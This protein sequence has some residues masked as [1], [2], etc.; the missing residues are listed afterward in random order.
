V[1]SG[2]HYEYLIEFDRW[3]GG[4][5]KL[6]MEPWRNVC[7]RPSVLGRPSYLRTGETD[8]KCD[9]M[10][11]L[12]LSVAYDLTFLILSEARLRRPEL[13]WTIVRDPVKTAGGRS[14]PLNLPTVE[15]EGSVLV[16]GIIGL[17]RGLLSAD[18]V[19]ISEVAAGSDA[20]TVHRILRE[21]VGS[22]R[23]LA[24]SGRR[25]ERSQGVREAPVNEAI[26]AGQR[27]AQPPGL[28]VECARAFRQ[29]GWFEDHVEMSDAGL[30]AAL[31]ASWYSMTE[32]ELPL[33]P[34]DVDW[35]VLILDGART[36]WGDAEA[37]IDEGQG[38]Y[39]ALVGELAV[40]SGGAFDAVDVVEDWQHEE[41][42]VLVSFTT[43]AER[44][45][46]RL[47]V[48]EDWIDPA[49]VHAVNRIMESSGRRFYFCDSNPQMGIVT[50]ATIRERNALERSRPIRLSEHSTWWEALGHDLENGGGQG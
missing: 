39:A 21:L 23:L 22:E 31:G 42:Y 4:W 13:E 8:K 16:L 46:V 49:I 48:I 29:A 14:F 43:K 38:C 36:W 5:W 33:E 44:V 40:R 1:E 20:L 2:A 26:A 47:K 11:Q 27:N 50:R 15:R 25:A 3:L 12:E 28:L 10:F 18:S 6:V 32:E 17:L 19:H 34:G 45:R 30:A 35:R 37:D 24:A 41:G 7:W 9:E